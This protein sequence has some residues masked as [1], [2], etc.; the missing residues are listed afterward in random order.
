MLSA[1]R[2][3]TAALDIPT[4]FFVAACLAALLGLFLIFAWLQE[5]HT[6]ALAWWGAAYL[7][8]ASSMALWNAPQPL[9]PVP[10]DLAGA[11]MFIAC[12]LHL[13]DRA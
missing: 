6:R 13:L 10:P 3:G 9:L 7:L 1:E 2:L 5:R 4:L 11:I 12:G 8:G